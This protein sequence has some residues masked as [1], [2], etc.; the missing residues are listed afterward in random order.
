MHEQDPVITDMTHLGGGATDRNPGP[1]PPGH[2][3]D[4]PALT[5]PATAVCGRWRQ[6]P[7]KCVVVGVIGHIRRRAP[8]VPGITAA[9]RGTWPPRALGK[10][11]IRGLVPEE[12]K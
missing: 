5:P 8:I 7:H 10:A 12:R 2:R 11:K 9:P 6:R 3:M 1:R 4:R